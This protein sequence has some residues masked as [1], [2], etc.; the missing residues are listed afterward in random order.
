MRKLGKVL[1]VLIKIESLE[2]TVILALTGEDSPS[3]D[4]LVVDVIG[5]SNPE[6]SFSDCH[7]SNVE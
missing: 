1:L 4:T 3:V 7:I 6:W 5:E 2:G